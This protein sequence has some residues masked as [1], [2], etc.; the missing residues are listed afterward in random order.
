MLKKTYGKNNKT[1]R[2]TFRLPPDV[3]AAEAYLCGDFN[4][5]DKTQYK[6]KPLKNG[7]FSTTIQLNA[8]SDYRF[9]YWLD[10]ATWEN[11]W[12]ADAYVP[13]AFGTEDSVVK[14]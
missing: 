7:G 1:A 13:N 3:E 4:D 5:W 8:G 9:R 2:V 14:V 12:E 10:G 6:M 11:D